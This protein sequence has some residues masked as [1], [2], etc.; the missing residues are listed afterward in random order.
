VTVDFR[1][2]YRRPVPSGTPIRIRGRFLRC[3][4][5]DYFVEGEILDAHGAALTRAEAR[6]RRI[7][8]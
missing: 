3:E 5:L 8:R 7:E 1:L 4:G 6:W 2:R